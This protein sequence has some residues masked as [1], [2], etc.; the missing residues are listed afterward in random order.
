MAWALDQPVCMWKACSQV[1]QLL[2][3]G[4]G[5]FR[6]KISPGSLSHGWPSIRNTNIR[7][8]D[9]YRSTQTRTDYLVLFRQVQCPSDLS[10]VDNHLLNTNAFHHSGTSLSKLQR[11]FFNCFAFVFG[12]STL[13]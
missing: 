1:T 13:D 6:G 5:W 3:L 4:I 11:S 10:I 2:S 9:S 7:K 8:H 12:F